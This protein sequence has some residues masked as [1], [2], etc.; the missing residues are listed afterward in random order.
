M[1]MAAMAYLAQYRE[2]RLEHAHTELGVPRVALKL[3]TQYNVARLMQQ[4]HCSLHTDEF[5]A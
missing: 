3:E 1:K 5:D 4:V 2:R